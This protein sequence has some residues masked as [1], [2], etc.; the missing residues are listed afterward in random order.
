[1]DM[2]S[3]KAAFA[4][5][6][7]LLKKAAITGLGT[8]AINTAWASDEVFIAKA[9][10][11][12]DDK[13]PADLD[14]SIL[15]SDARTCDDKGTCYFF[16]LAQQI[17][18]LRSGKWEGANGLNETEKYNIKLL[19]FAQSAAWFQDQFGGYGA[20]PNASALLKSL[21]S[22]E[23][24]PTLSYFVNMPVVDYDSA[25]AI[26]SE[27]TYFSSKETKP[28]SEEAFLSVLAHEVS[29]LNGWPYA[30]MWTK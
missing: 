5:T 30:K 14:L 26:D 8:S 1:M 12:I 11:N 4:N 28:S 10:K 25:K 6:T 21:Q 27:N 3:I 13:K 20:Q 2:D 23:T 22:N 9:S 7:T 17:S 18:N 29:T 24:R 19:E 15:G 16:V